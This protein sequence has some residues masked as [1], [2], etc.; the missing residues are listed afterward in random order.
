VS[1]R[2]DDVSRILEEVEGTM[3]GSRIIGFLGFS[4]FRA[5]RG[6]EDALRV[7]MSSYRYYLI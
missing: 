1:L 7:I 6:I 5:T 4:I 2:N 3:I